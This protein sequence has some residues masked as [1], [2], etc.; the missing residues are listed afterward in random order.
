MPRTGL[1]MAPFLLGLGACSSSNCGT[2]RDCFSESESPSPSEGGQGG[3][4][5]GA[6]KEDN[7]GG[8]KSEEPIVETA[9]CDPERSDSPDE[10]YSDTNC[11]GIDGDK[12]QAIFVDP[13]GDDGASGKFGEP[14]ASVTRAIALAQGAEKAIFVC[15]ATYQEQLSITSEAL[16]IYGGYS[17][18]TWERN[19]S[20]ATIQPPTGVPLVVQ[21]LDGLHIEQLR[22]VAADAKLVG[23]SSMAALI[24]DAKNVNFTRTEF[25]AGRGGAGASGEAGITLPAA[26]A[27]ADGLH[28]C[29]QG[30]CTAGPGGS[31]SY[32]DFC[33]GSVRSEPGGAGGD[34]AT[35]T[36][37]ARPGSDALSGASGG[38]M[39]TNL[40]SRKGQSGAKGRAGDMGAFAMGSVGTIQGDLYI[41]LNSG[42]AGLSGEGGK[43]GGGGAGG[44]L[45]NGIPGG[46]GGQGGYGG[47]GGRGG[48]GGG[49]GAGSFALVVLSAEV[50]LNQSQLVTG[51]GG[52]GGD[53]GQGGEGSLGGEG[54]TSVVTNETQAGG[55]GGKGGNGG[56]GGNGAPGGGGPS[57]AIALFDS[58]VPAVD[59]VTFDVGQGG[60]G[61]SEPSGS[62]AR[63][64][65]SAEGFDL[66][67]GAEVD[68]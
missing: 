50:S 2:T 55:P 9:A 1:V 27:G 59:E 32:Y 25:V 5:P 7:L 41:P 33:M 45:L 38:G 36:V 16:E 15:S 13:E 37:V 67:A 39:S 51:R 61:G 63:S 26:R 21:S 17:C 23:A 66:G 60:P 65:V 42:G 18:D 56:P 35:G 14:V 62:N 44:N 30:K 20:R 64:G 48:G 58:P 11:D 49:G 40:S 4:T 57:I 31:S 54:G 47:C 22:F 19:A 8:G 24:K 46:G 29:V 3:Q 68:F 43:A 34:G 6:G 52:P 28:T 53:G 10:K 12:T